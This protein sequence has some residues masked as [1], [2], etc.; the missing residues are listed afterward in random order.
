MYIVYKRNGN[1][2][3]NKRKLYFNPVA[4][5]EITPKAAITTANASN[6][7]KNGPTPPWLK[8]PN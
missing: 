1:G 8:N 4:K 5:N 3:A 7:S 2:K 6:G